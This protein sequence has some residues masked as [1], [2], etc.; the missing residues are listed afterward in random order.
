VFDAW[1]RILRAV[2]DAVLWL[3]RWNANVQAALERAAAERGIPAQ[4]LA[5]VPLLG[6]EEHLTRLACGDLYLDAWPCNAHTTAGEALWVGLPPV[7]VVGKPFAQRVA[8]S[9]MHTAGLGDLVC[10]DADAYVD[11]VVTLAR[12]PARR[13]ALRAQLLAQRDSNPLFDGRRFARDIEA[14]FG[15]MWSR[16]VAGLPPE[17]LPAEPSRDPN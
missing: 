11:T 5:F 7:T 4:R 13:D 1:C 10:D 15:R 9:L 16:A 8:A 3:L 6:A 2:P 14:L 12:D 17:H